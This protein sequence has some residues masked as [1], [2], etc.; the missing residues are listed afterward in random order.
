MSIWKEQE[1]VLDDVCNLSAVRKCHILEHLCSRVL[2]PSKHQ[3][4]D[5][6]VWF[7]CPPDGNNTNEKELIQKLKHFPQ[8]K[9]MNGS[10]GAKDE[11]PATRLKGG[12]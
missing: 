12:C 1:G 8:N 5:G 11:T 7:Y 2:H 3:L 9:N 10:G 4:A 6:V